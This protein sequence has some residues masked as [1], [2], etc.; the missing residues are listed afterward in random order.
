MPAELGV[1]AD[2]F[3]GACD[4]ATTVRA[5]GLSAAVVLGVPQA[6][7]SLPDA[8]C[9]VIALRS[10]TAP[11][12]RAVAE[13]VAAADTLL[14][15][16]TRHLY[17]KYCS[18]F[19]STD[20]GN[21]GPVADAIRAR[22]GNDTTNLTTP[23]TPVVGRTVYLAHLFVGPRLLSESSLRDHP[24]TPMRDPDLVRVLSRQTTAGVG[25]VVRPEV[26]DTA[27]VLACLEAAEARGA[28]HLVL[29][30]LREPDLD[31]LA[32]ALLERARTG[33]RDLWGGAAGLAGAVA[34]ALV[35]GG[36]TPQ[37]PAGAASTPSAQRTRGLVISGSCSQR[38]RAQVSAFDGPA[39][40]LTPEGLLRDRAGTLDDVL[41][42]LA[43]CYSEH[44]ATVPLVYTTDGTEEVSAAQH[45]W[46]ATDV[47][48]AIESALA[49]VAARSVAELGVEALLVAGGETSGAVCDA[50]GVH[51][52]HVREQVA[53]G[54]AWCTS[55]PDGGLRLLLKSGNFGDDHLFSTAWGR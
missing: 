46:G 15:A 24:L 35:R 55:T 50:L 32:D 11:V 41:T 13:S 28:R 37:V 51:E 21:I 48:R 45:A 5:A 4:L 47:A 54:L 6:A 53:P 42:E 49:E 14:G 7:Q 17:Q 16:G 33:A 18:T 30:A 3:T 26:E 27:A 12:D 31:L 38:T 25:P 2:D 8:D 39:I 1:V 10:R 20:D 19:D 23:A 43:R 44:E 22:L 9:V 52:L 34:R 36:R 29:D 40:R